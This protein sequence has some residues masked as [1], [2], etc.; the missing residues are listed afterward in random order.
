MTPGDL[1]STSARWRP[2]A[3]SKPPGLRAAGRR[4]ERSPPGAP[5]RASRH[6]DRDVTVGVVEDA[7]VGHELQVDWNADP[8]SCLDQVLAP[9]GMPR[10]GLPGLRRRPR[11]HH[12]L[13]LLR[14]RHDARDL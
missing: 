5:A 8:L 9:P 13:L 1:L 3:A 7:L 14:Q 11:R 10:A 6:P 4:R 12:E 2:R